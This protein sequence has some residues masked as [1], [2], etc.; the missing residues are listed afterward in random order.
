MCAGVDAGYLAGVNDVAWRF[1]CMIR[2][3]GSNQ[4]KGVGAIVHFAINLYL[5]AGGLKGGG[6]SHLVVLAVSG[7]DCLEDKDALRGGSFS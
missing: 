5:N 4:T 2:R 6:T 3:V 7:C 1:A